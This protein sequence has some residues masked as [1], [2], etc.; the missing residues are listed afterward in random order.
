MP[1]SELELWQ[2]KTQFYISALSAACKAEGS[3]D[4]SIFVDPMLGV[5]SDDQ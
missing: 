2:L 1:N 5:G 4:I 3:P